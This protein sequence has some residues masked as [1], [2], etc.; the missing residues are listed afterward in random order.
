MATALL[1][2]LVAIAG[3]PPALAEDPAADAPPTDAGD[4][5]GESG[6]GENGEDDDAPPPPGI[7]YLTEITA[8][9][10]PAL[11]A[12]LDGSSNLKRLQD[13]EARPGA[14]GLVRRAQEDIARLT[15][16]LRAYGYYAGT[17]DATI[18]GRPA[19]DDGL[20]ADLEP[21]VG[22]EDAVA[23]ALTVETGPLYTFGS[24]E[25]V[26]AVEGAALPPAALDAEIAAVA[27]APALA[28]AV[29][30][31]ERAIVRG[32]RRAGYPFAAV[33]GR[34]A[35]VDHASREMAVTYQVTAGPPAVFG[36]VTIEG[37][38]QVEEPFLRGRVGIEPG[39]PYRP[40]PLS[41]LRDD[42]V[43]LGVF[44]SVRVD[45]AEALTPD[46]R[47]PVTVTVVERPRRFIGFGAD[48]ATSE[49]FGARVFWG[50]RNLFG[51]AERL[52][53]EGEVGRIAENDLADVDFGLNLTFEK[54]DFLSR[55]QTLTARIEVGRENPDA[56]RRQAI[57]GEIGIERPL[58]AD[59]RLSVG[60]R[61]ELS[62]LEDADGEADA[63]QVVLVSVPAALIYD[64]T[65]DLLDPTEGVR[66]RLTLEPFTGDAT[67]L[68]TRLAASS[69]VDLLGDGDLVLAARAAVGS[70]TGADR[71]DVP[72]NRRF[73]A[74][75]G[76]SVRGF[77]FQ[78]IGP[79]AGDGDPL[80]GASLLE[81]GFEA[82]I[83]ITDEI[84]IVPFVEGG[85][86]YD[87]AFP[88]FSEDFQVGAGLGLRYYT[89]FGPLRV[90]VGVPVIRGDE[91]DDFQFYVSIGQA[92]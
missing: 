83:K 89:D 52:R 40:A 56:F 78:G 19:D 81:A 57:E 14:A 39:E 82:R 73:F 27:G 8:V 35:V 71:D 26:S 63:D 49:G 80:G 48:F 28:A 5:P 51:E 25:R 65:D 69:Y 66:A 31:G 45:E 90:D 12:A 20:I 76:G 60:L 22:G 44:T 23:V 74:G 11:A 72:E 77:S 24:V 32:L 38:E 9:D 88:D 79:R 10:D 62:E 36:P 2:A 15:R 34:R 41:R 43:A 1:L 3:P 29:L 47:L 84:G 68:R 17:V 70:I 4:P 86:V 61:A 58:T 13:D 33:S 7:A 87:S 55:D 18:D 59:L 30:D 67:F 53:I 50:H 92:F 91:D 37:L 64:T 46:G 16:A 21:L 54:P 85:A 42:F 75:G 6:D